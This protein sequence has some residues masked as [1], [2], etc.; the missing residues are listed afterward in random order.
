MADYYTHV[1]LVVGPM[2]QVERDWLEALLTKVDAE[3]DFENALY[4]PWEFQPAGAP[5]Q[6]TLWVHSDESVNLDVL[7][8]LLSSYLE[9]FHPDRAI[10]LEWSNT[11]SKPRPDGFGGGIC[12]ITGAQTHWMNTGTWAQEKI[13]ALNLKELA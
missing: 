1:S 4:C 10:V 7:S 11:C 5:D 13:A 9:R 6:F 12:V 2:P 3:P 8:D